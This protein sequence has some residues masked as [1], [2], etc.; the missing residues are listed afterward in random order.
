MTRRHLCPYR[1]QQESGIQCKQRR[2]RRQAGQVRSLRFQGRFLQ[3]L[4][5]LSVQDWTRRVQSAHEADRLRNAREVARHRTARSILFAGCTPG[6]C[7]LLPSLSATAVTPERIRTGSVL[8]A[9]E[10]HLDERHLGHR[11]G[12]EAAGPPSFLLNLKDAF[13]LARDY[14]YRLAVRQ[15]ARRWVSCSS[16]RAIGVRERSSHITEDSHVN[17]S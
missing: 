16:E 17:G 1:C 4:A 11:P 13:R 14:L 12:S 9:R 7:G 15:H 2:R 10:Y 3:I 5:G 8:G 6:P